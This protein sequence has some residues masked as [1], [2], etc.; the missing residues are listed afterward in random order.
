M[1][2]CCRQDTKEAII[3]IDNKYASIKFTNLYQINHNFSYFSTKT[4]HLTGSILNWGAV[5][6]SILHIL[7]RDAISSFYVRIWN[8]LGSW[9]VLFIRKMFSYIIKELLNRYWWILA[10][11]GFKM[12][13]QA[14][15]FLQ[16]TRANIHQYQFNNP[17]V[18]C[19][20]NSIWA[21]LW[22]IH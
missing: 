8:K 17:I 16:P 15:A 10:L 4:S 13:S 3:C 21:L 6:L 5:R 2:E 22:N 7:T 19:R 14:R 18:L 9:G 11:V 1:L 12:H 20:L